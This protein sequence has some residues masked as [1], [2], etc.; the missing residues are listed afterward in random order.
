M[1]G[2]LQNSV[3]TFS[4]KRAEGSFFLYER[5]VNVR[6]IKRIRI[7]YERIHY[8]RKDSIKSLSELFWPCQEK[9]LN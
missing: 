4:E 7:P 3:K 8:V 1:L 6:N 5:I 9:K 2:A